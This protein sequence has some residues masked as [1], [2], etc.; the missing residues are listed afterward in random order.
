MLKKVSS[1]WCDR[2]LWF[3]VFVL[4]LYEEFNM[5]V[6]YLFVVLLI[7]FYIVIFF[8]SVSVNIDSV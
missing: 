8:F 5:R 4:L 3:V 2:L 7:V 1:F 6:L